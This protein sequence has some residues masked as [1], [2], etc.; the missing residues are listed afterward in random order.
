MG[1][2]VWVRRAFNCQ[3]WLF[4]ARAV[5]ILAAAIV[6][7]VQNYSADPRCAPG[8]H[9]ARALL[10][11]T[12]SVPTSHVRIPPQSCVGGRKNGR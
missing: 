2:F 4:P 9:A 5:T 7:G 8:C 1:A 6:S 12:P 11:L 3:K 10:R